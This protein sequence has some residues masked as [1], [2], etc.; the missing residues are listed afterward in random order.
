MIDLSSIQPD[1]CSAISRFHFHGW[2]IN[3]LKK[4]FGDS[5]NLE[6]PSFKDRPFIPDSSNTGL[7]IGDS[8]SLDYNLIEKR[9]AIMI[10]R[11]STQIKKLNP[12]GG[13]VHSSTML[14]TDTR[15]FTMDFVFFTFLLFCFGRSPAESEILSWEVMAAI[16]KLHRSLALI[17]IVQN[18]FV[19]FV[20]E[21]KLVPESVRIYV[22]PVRARALFGLIAKINRT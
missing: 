14:T 10:Q 11:Q 17:G 4:Y 1:L 15:L 5:T 2:L 6:H 19:D 16:N 13:E 21:Q 9:P 18:L 20:G 12:F 8:S 7:I 3:F 22:T